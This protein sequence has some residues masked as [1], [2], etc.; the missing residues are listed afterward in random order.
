MIMHLG[1]MPEQAKPLL[2]TSRASQSEQRREGG[3]ILIV[4]LAL[5]GL[6]VATVMLVTTL[7]RSQTGLVEAQSHQAIARQNALNALDLA[8]GQL[9]FSAGTDRVITAPA[10]TLLDSDPLTSAPDGVVH[11][12]WTQVI[13]TTNGNANWLVSSGNG[14]PDPT[15]SI[16]CTTAVTLAGERSTGSSDSQQ[17]AVVERVPVQTLPNKLASSPQTT[18]YYAYWTGELNT[19]ANITHTDVIS[20]NLTDDYQLTSNQLFLPRRSAI[21]SLFPSISDPDDAETQQQ[22]FKVNTPQQLYFLQQNRDELRQHFHDFTTVSQSVLSNPISGGLKVNLTDPSYTDSLITSTLR[23]QITPSYYTTGSPQTYQVQG[24]DPAQVFAINDIPDI[25]QP[26]ALHQP[27]ITE[28]SLSMGIFHAHN[29]RDK[30]HRIRYHMYAEFL[31]PY[32]YD[33]GFPSERPYI[34]IADNLPTLR[35]TNESSG[36]SYEVDLNNFPSYPV[37]DNINNHPNKNKINTWFIFDDLNNESGTFI[38]GIDAG[39]VYR[40][41][42]PD[43]NPW[44]NH[45]TG[46]VRLINPDPWEWEENLP[47][48]GLRAPNTLYGTDT[49][50]IESLSPVR[51]NITLVPLLGEAKMPKQTTPDEFVKEKGYITK[52]VNVP[53]EDIDIHLS[54]LS[55]SR[56]KS[57]DFS[58]ADY[59]MAFHFKLK[60]DISTLRLL[61]NLRD[62]RKVVIDFDDAA[63][64]Q[65]YE[66]MDVA[67]AAKTSEPASD[68]EM[69]WDFSEGENKATPNPDEYQFHLYDVPILEPLSPGVFSQLHFHDR[70]HP[71]IGSP[72]AA[73]SPLNQVYDRYYFSGSQISAGWDTEPQSWAPNNPAAG[74]LANHLIRPVLQSGS[75]FADA[76]Q[77]T[78]AQGAANSMVEGGFNIFSSSPEAWKTILK[79]Q[80]K[81]NSSLQISNGTDNTDTTSNV[82]SRL[83]FGSAKIEG[84]LA[85]SAITE[86]NKRNKLLYRQGVRALDGPA[87]DAQLEA[88][89][90]SIVSEIRSDIAGS[91]PG[92]LPITSMRDLINAGTIDRAIEK[93]SINDTIDPLS[94]G[95]LRQSDIFSL[96]GTQITTR[97]DTFV[98]R[99]YGEST[100]T[101]NGGV[102]AK[103]YCEAMVQRYPDYMIPS[104]NAA[105]TPSNTMNIIM[106]RRFRV[107]SFRW[108]QAHDI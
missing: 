7:V 1:N 54:G 24:D 76:A 78:S 3:F 72:N 56:E 69:F 97:S 16:D 43:R 47:E 62:F 68:Q 84:Q 48:S 37:S 27:I 11:P 30:M 12:Y 45:D 82:F 105:S 71:W 35:V 83:P 25:D 106:G 22:I 55:Y 53:F 26:I 67:A 96:L 103:A 73:S 29:R 42:E 77:M 104:D 51:M 23:E 44:N 58:P 93:T 34:I 89:A 9:Q 39:T 49:I 99:C 20:D 95:Y 40:R 6:A 46:I 91:T 64:R 90:E 101:R 63:T 50:H 5:L 86:P 31:N 74:V 100:D 8:I 87:G 14:N 13:D 88:L 32:P 2:F 4:T 65:M 21:E 18:G 85:D 98:I 38:K 92:A 102:E 80:F 108:M 33:I 28:F 75:Q 61:G 79:N 17:W 19:R 107:V 59:R 60:E 66:T 70:P 41:K 52:I 36:A 10:A 15:A 57:T 81:N 94:P